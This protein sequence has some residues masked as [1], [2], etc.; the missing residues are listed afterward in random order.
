MSVVYGTYAFFN[1]TA[2]PNNSVS[3]VSA[4]ISFSVNASVVYKATNLIPVTEANMDSTVNKAS[5]NCRDNDNR[6]VCSLYKINIVNSGEASALNGYVITSSSTYTTNNL[7]YKV[8]TKSGNVYT[9]V[10]DA[11]ILSHNSGDSVYFK[12]NNVNL[13]TNIAINETKTYYIA[14]W[15]NEVNGVQN[16]DQEQ[17]YSCKIGFEGLNG[18]SLSIPFNV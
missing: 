14:F 11:M 2:T 3:G 9:A 12:S 6:D 13:T 8:Y 4:D 7:K 5:N 10:T 16:A 17:N 15:I 18:S 1:A